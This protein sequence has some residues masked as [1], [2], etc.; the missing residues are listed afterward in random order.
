MRRGGVRRSRKIRLERR[1]AFGQ[2]SDAR[3]CVGDICRNQRILDR[4]LLQQS[5]RRTIEGNGANSAS[6]PATVLASDCPMRVYATA[7][8]ERI[9]V[10]NISRA[11]KYPAN[12]ASARPGRR[13]RRR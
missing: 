6:P 7:L 2:L 4:S 1:Q 5:R 12:P 3:L 8:V 10:S 11:R 13:H 9:A